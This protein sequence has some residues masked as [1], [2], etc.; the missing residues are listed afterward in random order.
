MNSIVILLIVCAGVLAIVVL[1]N[2]SNINITE[3]KREIATIKVLGFYNGEVLAYIIRENFLS[4]LIGIIFGL[5]LGVFLH[6]FVVITSEV[7][8]VMFN[9]NL[10]WWAYVF[11]FLLTVIFS[12]AVNFVL[13]FK[14]K[15]IE[16]VE[17]L[18]SVE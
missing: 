13:Y 17:S 6:H 16:M 9:R 5:I 10:V 11:A 2:L 4:T 18:K 7:D 8:I 12:V 1:Y 3:R 15:K 14:L